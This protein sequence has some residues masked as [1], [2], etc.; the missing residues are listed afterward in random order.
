MLSGII[1]WTKRWS[2]LLG[3]NTLVLHFIDKMA[4]PYL[5]YWLSLYK[6]GQIKCKYALLAGVWINKTMGYENKL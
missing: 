6:A 2:N 5:A 1:T 4:E 3:Q